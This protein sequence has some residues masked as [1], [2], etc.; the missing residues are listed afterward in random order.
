MLYKYKYLKY[1]NKY[2]NLINGGH[3]NSPCIVFI[4][5]YLDIKDINFNDITLDIFLSNYKKDKPYYFFYNNNLELRGIK[6]NT[7]HD[8]IKVK[9]EDIIKLINEKNNN[10]EYIFDRKICIFK[11]KNEFYYEN[12][13]EDDETTLYQ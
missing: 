7:L 2:L 12:V 8:N 11:N 13:Y 9:N 5:K 6:S 1:K 4:D 10:N 3:H